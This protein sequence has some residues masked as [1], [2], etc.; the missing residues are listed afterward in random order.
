MSIE[1]VS[2]RVHELS[3][4]DSE[5]GVMCRVGDHAVYLPEDIRK[6]VEAGDEVGVAGDL[7]D[8]VLRV[9]AVSPER[10]DTCQTIDTSNS[11]IVLCFAVF[12]GVMSGLLGLQQIGTGRNILMFVLDAASLLALLFAVS[13]LIRIYRVI[14]ASRRVR[15]G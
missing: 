12:I 13:L 7:E 2:G 11:A 14:R 3:E 15:F 1:H 5:G 9:L 6:V 10:N 4:P 8:G